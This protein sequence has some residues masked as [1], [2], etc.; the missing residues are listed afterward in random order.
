MVQRRLNWFWAWLGVIAIGLGFVEEQLYGQ[1][2]STGAITGVT[3]DP[4]GAALPGVIVR[5]T[6]EGGGEA[7]S[8]TSD[9]GGRFG[10]LLVPPGAYQLDAQKTDFDPLPIPD[11][12][13]TVTETLH[14]ELRLQLATRHERAESVSSALMVDI[15]NSA[16]G[17]DV[18]QRAVSSLPLVTRNFT[19]IAGLSPGVAGGVMNAGELGLGGMALSQIAKSNDGIYVH[20]ARS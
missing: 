2:A 16:L 9:D 3:L 4:S 17:R 1:T 18:G 10:F 12:H 15:D 11:I 8:T 20:G 6:K 7:K 13:V 19:Q 14:V 5:L